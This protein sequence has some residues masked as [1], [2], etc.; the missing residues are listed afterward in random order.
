MRQSMRK[1]S[2]LPSTIG[3][4]QTGGGDFGVGWSISGLTG[5]SSGRCVAG[6]DAACTHSL[7][8]CTATPVVRATPVHGMLARPCFNLRHRAATDGS[9][10]LKKRAQM[11][12]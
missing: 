9:H 3:A 10:E 6:F 5:T 12:S 11:G 4:S 8:H 2:S 7:H 1:A